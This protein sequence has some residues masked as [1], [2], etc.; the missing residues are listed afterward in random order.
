MN[1]WAQWTSASTLLAWVN[2]PQ[3]MERPH[4]WLPGFY[5]ID[6]LART[7]T[8][9]VT[10]NKRPPSSWNGSLIVTTRHLSPQGPEVLEATD[11]VT[12]TTHEVFRMPDSQDSSIGWI[13][14]TETIVFTVG[15]FDIYLWRPGWEEARLLETRGQEALDGFELSPD[16]RWLAIS[17]AEGTTVLSL[18]DPAVRL[19]PY[20]DTWPMAWRPDGQALMLSANFCAQVQVE[21]RDPER[22]N[23]L[24]ILDVDTGTVRALDSS[25]NGYWGFTWSPEGDRGLGLALGTLVQVW[26][27]H[28]QSEVVPWS[29]AFM[30]EG[31]ALDRFGPSWSSSGRWYMTWGMDGGHGSACWLRGAE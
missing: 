26:P 31:L 25:G 3:G 14:A 6:L 17:G 21:S 22:W 10:S 24:T 19:G 20:E 7:V 4:G 13:E 23:N 8:L 9:T 30:T 1:G 12:G 11:V 29:E 2:A 15:E 16:G 5:E 18:D 27:E 28:D